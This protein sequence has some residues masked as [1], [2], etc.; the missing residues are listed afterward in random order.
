MTEV[1][2]IHNYFDVIYTLFCRCNKKT[3]RNF[4]EITIGY[5]EV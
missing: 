4:G 3:H 2:C 5:N 1:G